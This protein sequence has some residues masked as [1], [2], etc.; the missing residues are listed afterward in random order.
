MRMLAHGVVQAEVARQ[1]EVSRQ[2]VSIW[3]KALGEDPQAWRGRRLGRPGG[4]TDAQRTQLSKALLA[5]ALANDF[6]TELWTLARVAKLIKREFGMS[7][8]TVH[9]WRLLKEMGFSSQ[10][11]SA[12]ATQR[13]EPA[14]AQ[15]K[16]RRW[17]LLKK[18]PAAK[19]ASLSSSTKRD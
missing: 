10:R 18:K 12:R 11:P 1:L 2:T 13:D 3:A 19:G 6:P 17:P 4:L 8:S 16:A 14:I 7:Y 5:G 15:W 9:V